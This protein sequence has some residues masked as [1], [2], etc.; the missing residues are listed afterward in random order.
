V[1]DERLSV[2][3]W[4]WPPALGVVLLVAFEVNLGHPGVPGWL[5]VALL[6]P[7][8]AWWLIRLGSARVTVVESDAGARLLRVGPARL[9]VDL[10]GTAEPIAPAAKRETLGPALDPAA[11]LVHRAWVGPMVRISINDPQDP[12]PYWLFS[13][14]K[15][16]KL[17]EQL[18]RKGP[19]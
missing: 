11:Y 19:A 2:P 1:F 5:P 18:A 8:V 10:I 4:W 7:L 13:V 3:W 12:T 16:E 17:L 15:P 6:A 9:P 14:R